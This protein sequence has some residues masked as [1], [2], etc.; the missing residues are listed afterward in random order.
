MK[1]RIFSNDFN[2]L[3]DATKG[4][5]ADA[6]V[7]VRPS[8][9]YIK[10]VFEASIS[11][12]TAI[13]VDGYRMSVEHCVV[14]DCDADFVAFIKPTIRLPRGQYF[15][16]ELCDNEVAIKG[17]DFS[18]S[19]PQPQRVDPFD[20]KKVIPEKEKRVFR[21]GFNGN[22]LM[23]ALQA[24]KVSAGDTFK[25]PVILEFYGETLPALIRTNKDDIKMVLPVR[26]KADEDINVPSKDGGK[27]NA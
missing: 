15:S 19:Y 10:L 22:Y 5:L 6:D 3:L 7:V 26:L 1:A 18:F 25:N 9:S 4:F 8:L 17:R 13:A 20:F 16:I 24:A 27:D 21:I 14:S 23:T 11:R 2:R 12:V